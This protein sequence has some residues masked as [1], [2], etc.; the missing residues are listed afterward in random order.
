MTEGA[1]FLFLPAGT[2]SHG[3]NGTGVKH[4]VSAWRGQHQA[5]N[6]HTS[7]PLTVHVTF[8]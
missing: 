7:L 3:M 6:L 5:R 4:H 1:S 8:V 2:P